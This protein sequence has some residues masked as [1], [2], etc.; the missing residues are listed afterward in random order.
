MFKRVMV[1]L[2]GSLLAEE[3]LPSALAIAHQFKAELI[4][5]RV[6]T[7]QHIGLHADGISYAELFAQLREQAK[8]VAHEYLQNH[9]RLLAEQGFNV[10]YLLIEDEFVAESLLEQANTEAIDLIIMST[11]GRS[12]IRRWVFGSVAD[13]VLR[14]AEVPVMLIRVSGGELNLDLLTEPQMQTNMP[15]IK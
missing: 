14:Q 6:V 10:R 1:P 3:A 12:G 11:H 4:L 13:K 2:D 9:Q 15:P 8:Q 5:I 7:P